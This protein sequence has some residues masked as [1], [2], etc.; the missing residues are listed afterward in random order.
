MCVFS[1][2][3]GPKSLVNALVN[4]TLHWQECSAASA[5]APVLTH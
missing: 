5:D 4:V 2:A 1:R 3:K